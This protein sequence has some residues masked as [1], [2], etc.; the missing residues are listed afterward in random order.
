MIVTAGKIDPR[1]DLPLALSAE[2]FDTLEFTKERADQLTQVLG[3]QFSFDVHRMDEA[4]SIHLAAL[5]EK[6][7]EAVSVFHFIGHGTVRDDGLHF[8]P[9]IDD[10]DNA[11]TA[12]QQW[13]CLVV[14][15]V[16]RAVA[17][18]PV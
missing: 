15:T 1:D 10:F 8:V 4:K 6:R 16:R 7:P 17:S 12:S 3:E 18:R 14:R 9:A 5:H 13:H 2:P 11:P